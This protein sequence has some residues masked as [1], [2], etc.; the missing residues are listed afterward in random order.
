MALS[1]R[2]RHFEQLYR[3]IRG[4]IFRFCMAMNFRP[5]HQQAKFLE[6]VQEQTLLPPGQ[7]KRRIAVASGR[8]P[9]KSC[10]TGLAMLWRGLHAFDSR[11]WVT[12]PAMR[13]CG[14]WLEECAKRVRRACPEL[15]RVINATKSKIEFFGMRGW[16]IN[17]V[18]SSEPV[19]FSGLHSPG[20]TILEDEASGVPRGVHE[21]IQ[22]TLTNPDYLW[23][24]I[25][26]PTCLS[27]P[28]YDCF[29]RQRNEW[30]TMR[31]NA[32]ESPDELVNKEE[33]RRAER[34]YGRDSDYYRINILGLFPHQD[35]NSVMSPADLWACVEVAPRDAQLVKHGRRTF[36]IDFARYGGDESVIYQMSGCA[37]VDYKTFVHTDPSKVVRE[38][39][40]MQRKLGWADDDCWY[41]F[42]AN[43]I[44]EGVAHMFYEA[45]KQ[46]HEFRGQHRPYH[47][48][49]KNAITEAYFGVR[50]LAR[51]RELHIPDDPRLVEQ[52]S[53]R[54]YF[55]SRTDGKIILEPK[56]DFMRRGYDSPDRAD[57]LVMACYGELDAD[58]QSALGGGSRR[59]ST[60][61]AVQRR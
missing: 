48:D 41:I 36:G 21:T 43:G 25:G 11:H 39:F 19:K 6:A 47:R 59:L 18:T 7:G 9:G 30:I 12:A 40:D 55:T 61:R 31:W 1:R 5:S 10:V 57:A 49:F 56:D 3:A 38:S 29:G 22:G 8:G 45:G 2:A 20:M 24:K 54:H 15:R 13:Q 14:N 17:L 60:P 52:L 35:P 23:I 28:F 42:D 16:D 53:A 58:G 33:H 32:E 34:E 26:N 37:V 50:R 4:D 44:G 51:A 27:S 46:V